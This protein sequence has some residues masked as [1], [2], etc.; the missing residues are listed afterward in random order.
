MG[1][2]D[3]GFRVSDATIE[4]AIAGVISQPH[5]RRWP[6]RLSALYMA[7]A[8]ALVL[9]MGAALNEVLKPETCVT[10]ACQLDTLSDEELA[11]MMDLMEDEASLG[12]E[13]EVWPTLY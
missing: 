12:L 11:G 9:G 10:F 4:A 3:D 7:A 1:Q 2:R 13:E 8:V 5:V 6:R